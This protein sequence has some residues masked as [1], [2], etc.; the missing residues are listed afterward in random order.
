MSKMNIG[1]V[2]F[3]YVSV[4]E[5]REDM[6]GDMKYSVTML[7]PKSN[8]K[9]IAEI[10]AAMSQAA[11]EG[12]N[13]VFGGKMPPSGVLAYPIHDGDGVK[14]NG[15]PFGDECKGMLVMT[16][17]TNEKYPP[18]VIRASDR[19]AIT[20][21]REIYS[22]CYGYV[23]VKFSAYNNRKVGVGCYLNNV[24]K[25]HEGEP[26]AGG[27][28]AENDFADIQIGDAP[29]DPITGQPYAA[30]T[31]ATNDDIATDPVTGLPLDMFDD[32]FPL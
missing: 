6:N 29:V 28:T 13:K 3:S 18:Q 15:Q 31:P 27:S 20:D 30:P 22:G 21:P 4:L 2:R 26:L 14:Q 24:M 32:S 23:S 8:T 1:E 5:P 10:K 19:K 25:T 11:Q 7:I 12:L 9:L 17:A 16:A